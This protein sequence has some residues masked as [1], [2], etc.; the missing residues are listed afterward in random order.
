MAG[1][2]GQLNPGSALALLAGQGGTSYISPEVMEAYTTLTGQ[3]Y[4]YDAIMEGLKYQK[5]R[6][7]ADR[8]YKYWNAEQTA[9]SAERAAQIAAGAYSQ[10]AAVGAEADMY[11]A[12]Q[13]LRS[14]QEAAAAARYA[15]DKAL[16]GLKISEENKIK[17]AAANLNL[18]SKRIAAEEMG[19]P[20]DWRTQAGYLRS[21]GMT[22]ADITPAAIQQAGQA[23]GPVAPEMAPQATGAPAAA[24]AAP[25]LPSPQQAVVGEAGPELATAT[26]QGT[27]VQPIQPETAWWLR[28]TGTPGMQGGGYLRMPYGQQGSDWGQ[29]SYAQQLPQSTGP[30]GSRWAIRTQALMGQPRVREAMSA[31][32]GTADTTAPPATTPP[33]GPGASGA[34]AAEPPYLGMLRENAYVPLWEAWQGPRTNPDV[35]MDIPIQMPHEINYGNFVRLTPT[36]QQMAFADWHSLGMAPD[37]ALRIMQSSAMRGTARAGIGYG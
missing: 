21:Q 9:Q 26:P 14:A 31:R 20:S 25:T 12:D 32:G 1:F 2:G 36:E 29:K 3:G 16:E 28:K 33:V 17:I 7:D 6:D 35:G 18:E 15:A 30:T 23:L 19:A 27:Q 13:S 4:S 37:T 5:E 8:E 11:A 10:A 34:T 24:P 22:H